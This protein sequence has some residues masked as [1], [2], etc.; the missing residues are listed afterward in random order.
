MRVLASIGLLLPAA[1]WGQWTPD[2]D[3]GWDGLRTLDL[4]P[5]ERVEQVVSDGNG[6]YVGFGYVGDFD[7]TG[8]DQDGVLVHLDADGALVEGFGVEGVTAFD[9]PGLT[10]LEPVSA[11]A[12]DAGVTTLS[13]AFNTDVSDDQPFALARHLWDGTPDGAFGTNGFTEVNFLGWQNSPEWLASTSNGL[14]ACGA[15]FDTNYVH[16][17]VPVL[18]RLLPDGT[19]DAEFGGG[20]LA[21]DVLAL[22]T[23]GV[24][25]LL[26]DQVRAPHDYGGVF[27]HVLELPDARLLCTGAYYGPLGYEC[28]ATCLHPSGAVDTTFADGGLFTF[29]FDPGYHNWVASAALLPSG[30]L[31]LA[32]HTEGSVESNAYTLTLSTEGTLVGQSE[33]SHVHEDL[34]CLEVA[35]DGTVWGTGRMV[36]PAN[37]LTANSADYWFAAAWNTA[38]SEVTTAWTD[39][40]DGLHAGQSL[41]LLADETGILLAGYVQNPNAEQFSDLAF[42]RLTQP[43]SVEALTAEQA[44][45]YPNPCTDGFHV[46]RGMTGTLYDAAGRV[47]GRDLEGWTRV[48]GLPAGNYVLRCAEA[49]WAVV[50]R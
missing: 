15:S 42:V 33:W 30:Q 3:F 5:Y 27:H 34:T 38:G 50:V 22:E 41:S 18:V 39:L 25:A 28:M 1:L 9:H 32:V 31:A 36:E 45:P 43:V 44:A 7:A 47:V 10:F 20:K 6:G 26:D 8:Y 13:R 37:D 17:E 24:D 16:R 19:P 35:P 40:A 14:V 46:P 21:F 12:D 11:W 48:S 23:V 4:A 29:N 2:T 49:A